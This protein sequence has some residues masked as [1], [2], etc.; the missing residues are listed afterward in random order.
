MA[1]QGTQDPTVAFTRRARELL[2]ISPEQRALTQAAG[3]AQLQDIFGGRAVEPSMQ[4]LLKFYFGPEAP[5]PA[6]RREVKPAMELGLAG[7]RER[8]ATERATAA[9][10]AREETIGEVRWKAR[11]QV[12]GEALRRLKSALGIKTGQQVPE[13]L[14]R[15]F[16][17]AHA[18]EMTSGLGAK[19][20]WPKLGPFL[21]YMRNQAQAGGDASVV[22]REG[23]QALLSNPELLRRRF[24]GEAGD[25]EDALRMIIHPRMTKTPW[26]GLGASRLREH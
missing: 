15:G 12:K 2:G 3:S 6:A 17:I 4:D 10:G 23:A 22:A 7:M 24:G 21:S 8:G 11:N 9:R 13:T 1:P 5:A 16:E 20:P 26:F 25:A 19:N 18:V 14:R